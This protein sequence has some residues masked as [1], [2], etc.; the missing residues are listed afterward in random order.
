VTNGIGEPAESDGHEWQ[1]K[2]PVER[3]RYSG[4]ARRDLWAGWTNGRV[5]TEPWRI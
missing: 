4:G 3:G 2:A 1:H 5:C